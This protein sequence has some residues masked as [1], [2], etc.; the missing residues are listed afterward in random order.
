MPKD[1]PVPSQAKH[2]AW[3]GLWLTVLGV[4]ASSSCRS[5]RQGSQISCEKGH[6]Y[7]QRQVRSGQVRS[8]QM[9]QARSCLVSQSSRPPVGQ[10][11][12]LSTRSH[13]WHMADTPPCRADKKHASSSCTPHHRGWQMPP[14]SASMR[15]HTDAASQ[16]HLCTKSTVGPVG[17]EAH[18]AQHSVH[19]HTKQR[20]WQDHHPKPPLWAQPPLWSHASQVTAAAAAAPP[21]PSSPSSCSLHQRDVSSSTC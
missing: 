10:S 2:A 5:T 14:P 7:T 20:P 19:Q 16:Q 12:S 21:G 8:G 9:R 17:P 3:Q 18:R 6:I 1:L 11:V 13:T 15:A 4:A